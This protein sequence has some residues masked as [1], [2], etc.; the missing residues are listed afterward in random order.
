VFLESVLLEMRANNLEVARKEVEQALKIHFNTGRLWAVKIQLI[1]LLNL[2]SQD[3]EEQTKSFIEA[4]K[5]VPKSGEVWCE[6]ARIAI[7]RGELEKA[8]QY[9]EFAIQ[10]TPQYGDSFIESLR[11]LLLECKTKEERL[12]ILNSEQLDYLERAC[13]NAEPTYG[14][15]WAYFRTHPFESTKQCFRNAKNLMMEMINGGYET[16]DIGVYFAEFSVHTMDSQLK[17]KAIFS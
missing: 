9:L 7:H 11:L 3:T 12:E 5:N 2:K 10:F 15:C 1:H 6:G 4:L 8:K 16:L 14:V 17:F 13:I